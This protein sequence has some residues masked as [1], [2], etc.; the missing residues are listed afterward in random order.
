MEV[1]IFKT[2]V[3]PRTEKNQEVGMNNIFA[4][5][6]VSAN[7]NQLLKKILVSFWWEKQARCERPMIMSV[8]RPLHLCV[9]YSTEKVVI[10]YQKAVG[11]LPNETEKEE[12]EVHLRVFASKIKVHTSSVCNGNVYD[13]FGSGNGLCLD[14]FNSAIVFQWLCKLIVVETYFYRDH[15]YIS[16][17]QLMATTGILISVIAA[18]QHFYIVASLQRSKPRTQIRILV[19]EPN[20]QF[21]LDWLDAIFVAGMLS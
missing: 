5:I 3:K 15:N 9:I 4:V 8:W 11:Q 20:K 2:F 16:K 21:S 13:T 6:L 7:I 19:Y 14:L 10:M 1:F 17:Y 18:G 12:E